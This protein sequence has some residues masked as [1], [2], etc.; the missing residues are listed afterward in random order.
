MRVQ[1]LLALGLIAVSMQA[2]VTKAPFGTTKDGKA[3]EIYT[4]KDADLEVKVMTYGARI[5]SVMAPDRKG[6]KADV[7]LGHPDI[8]GYQ[9]DKSTYFGAVVGRYGNRIAKGQFTIDGHSYQVPVNNNG[10]SLHGGT[11][12]FDNRVWTAKMIPDGVEMT[13]VSP[14]GD[15]GYPGTLTAHVRY[16]LHGHDLRLDYSA[17]TDKP[18]VTNLTNHAYFNLAGE[19]SGTILNQT[20]QINADRY[21]P[22]DKVLIP[23]GD[24]PPVAG[25]PFDFRTPHAIGE[26]ID[27]ANDQLT[28]AG[29]YDHNWVL[30]GPNGTMKMAAK[31]VDPASGRT[32]TVSTTQ[33]GVQFYT[34][35]FLVDGAITGTGG[36]TYV[37]RGAFCL[38]TQH[39]PDSPN[40]PAFPTTLLK[41]GETLHST[42]VFSFG[43][44]K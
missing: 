36:K 17:T 26:R 1:T 12:G 23:T 44:E 27:S 40:H 20:I 18:T 30:N 34:G 7:V 29:G 15:Q 22:V 43:V 31:V 10:Q 2:E 28:I 21:T 42:T 14:D 9:T 24:L 6:T 38:E 35:N 4:L 8:A 32:L 33:P 37:R 39:F 3:V 11:D 41:P 25:T 13:L 5:Q 19:G 16:T